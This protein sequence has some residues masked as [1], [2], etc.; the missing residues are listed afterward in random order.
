MGAASHTLRVDA[1]AVTLTRVSCLVALALIN[2]KAKVP[3]CE[4]R[5]YSLTLA[6]VTRTF[7]PWAAVLL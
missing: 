3:R 4:H 7:Q 6:P 2:Q 1:F 5:G